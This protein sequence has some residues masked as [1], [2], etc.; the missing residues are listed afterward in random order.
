MTQTTVTRND[1][2]GRYEILVDGELGGF[3][4]FIAGDGGVVLTHTETLPAFSG[5]GLGPELARAAVADAVAR[6]L[7]IT[8]LCPFIRRYLERNDIPGAV[9]NFP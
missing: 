5:R 8:P 3:V 7:T 1:G 9:I 6:G 2:A 4:D